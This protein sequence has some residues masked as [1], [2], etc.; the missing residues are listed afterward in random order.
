[1]GFFEFCQLCCFVLLPAVI[2]HYFWI[3]YKLHK[4]DEDS[5]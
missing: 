4:M 2:G 5:K 1:M 3:E